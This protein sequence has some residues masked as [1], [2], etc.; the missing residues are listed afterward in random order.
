MYSNSAY[1]FM[2]NFLLDLIH[3]FMWNLYLIHWLYVTIEFEKYTLIWFNHSKVECFHWNAEGTNQSSRTVLKK[4]ICP[5]RQSDLSVNIIGRAIWFS[6]LRV[7]WKTAFE[8]IWMVKWK[9]I[10][11]IWTGRSMVYKQIRV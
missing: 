7:F 4:K 10:L 5:S 6:L 9:Q 1:F 3:D 2:W 11:K 8:P